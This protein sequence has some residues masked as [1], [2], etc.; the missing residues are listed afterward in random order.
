MLDTFSYSNLQ[1]LCMKWINL[2]AVIGILT[3]L[4][5]NKSH[6]RIDLESPSGLRLASSSQELKQLVKNAIKNDFIDFRNLAIT[7]VEYYEQADK[8][9]AII[10]YAFGKQAYHDL[11]YIFN[12]TPAYNANS[13][14]EFVPPP[15]GF[16]FRCTSSSCYCSVTITRNSAGQVESAECGGGCQSCHFEQTPNSN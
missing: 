15:G 10:H 3:I 5:C 9:I 8:T 14:E 13:N 7:K 12:A 2:I 6:E 1:T 16:L 11:I 4:G